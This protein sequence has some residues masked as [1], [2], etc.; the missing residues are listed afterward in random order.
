GMIGRPGVAAEMFA[1]LARR[2]INIRMIST[3]EVKVSC[4]ID[5]VDC[6]EAVAALRETFEIE[7]ESTSPAP[8]RASSPLSSEP[9]VRGVALD[10]KQAR[11]GIRRVPD[12]PGMAEKIFGTLASHNISVDMIIQSQRCHVVKAIQTRDIAFTVARVDAHAAQELLQ[13]ATA[14]CGWGEVVL[15]MEIAK[16]SIVGAGMVGQPGIA[17]K[18][19]ESLS[20][21]N[22]NIQ[23]ITTSE[24]KISCVVAQDQ[25]V[26]ALKAIH[27]AFEL[28]GE[29][30]FVVPG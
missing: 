23:M 8:S 19:F 5:S 4:V 2:G 14:E 16:V 21:E 1:T 26:K 20:E 30:E 27:T 29:E 3:S 15:D 28:G 12:K 11:L 25:G 13:K 9:P 18:M 6:D 7:E 17:A 10:M 22:I 24:I